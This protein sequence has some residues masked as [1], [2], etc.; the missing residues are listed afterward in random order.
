VIDRPPT[1]DSLLRERPEWS[2]WVA[3]LGACH[4]AA[5]DPAWDDAAADAEVPAPLPDRPLL[6]GARIAVD[7][8]ATGRFVR[9][10]LTLAADNS[11]PAASLRGALALDTDAAVAVLEAAVV[12]DRAR[13]DAVAVELGA[14]PGAL[15][16]LAPLLGAPLLRACARRLAD[17]VPVSWTAGFCPVCASW[18]VVAEEHGLERGRRFRCGRCAA[19]WPGTWLRCPFC[20]NADHRTLGTLVPD[21][22]ASRFVLTCQACR[23]YVKTLTV[24]RSTPAADLDVLDLATVEL[25]VVALERG[26]AR[27][28]APARLLET[29]VIGRPRARRPWL[30]LLG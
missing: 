29:R 13:L 4:R 6:H 5:D 21:G 10:I 8:R 24:L 25:D 27:P 19:D 15:T 1:L 12:G 7:G 17:R 28:A 14:A 16:A 3:L 23:G 9:E 22:I 11:G 30:P 2:G 20:D 18:P 26:Y